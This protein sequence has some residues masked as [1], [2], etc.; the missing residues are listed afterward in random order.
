MTEVFADI[1]S[2]M[3]CQAKERS[4][5][6]KNGEERSR[7]VNFGQ[8]AGFIAKNI[9]QKPRAPWRAKFENAFLHSSALARASI[10]VA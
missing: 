8:L 6:V 3:I 10:A 7:S 4:R 9:I 1:L 5:T 2:D